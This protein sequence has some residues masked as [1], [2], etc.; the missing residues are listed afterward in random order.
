MS[1]NY[2]NFDEDYNDI[3]FNLLLY[4]AQ[5]ANRKLNNKIDETLQLYKDGV[6]CDA[7]QIKEEVFTDYFK[8]KE[9]NQF[10]RE[11]V[12]CLEKLQNAN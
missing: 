6:T 8:I 2:N 4:T 1:N 7:G 11:A 12:D 10:I 5:D 3:I 9:S